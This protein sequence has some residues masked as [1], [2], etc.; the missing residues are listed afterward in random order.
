MFTVWLYKKNDI[1]YSWIL[2]DCQSDFQD[3]QETYNDFCDE[4]DLVNA[5]D[6]A[7]VHIDDTQIKNALAGE[8]HPIEDGNVYLQLDPNNELC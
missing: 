7:V 5:L 3:A 1:N 2:V 4:L 8:I 6:V